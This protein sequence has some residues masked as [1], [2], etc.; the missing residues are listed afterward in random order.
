MAGLTSFWFLGLSSSSL[1]ES[2]QIKLAGETGGQA[3]GKRSSGKIF[4]GCYCQYL[5][6]CSTNIGNSLADFLSCSTYQKHLPAALLTEKMRALFRL[7]SYDI[8][9]SF[10][11]QKCTPIFSWQ[12]AILGELPR[13]GLCL[14]YNVPLTYHQWKPSL[15]PIMPPGRRESVITLQHSCLDT[16]TPLFKDILLMSSTSVLSYT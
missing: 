12:D 9:I 16:S 1:S 3:T 15:L 10:C 2:F 8:S 13:S 5:L 7:S 4:L 14:V 11:I 6:K